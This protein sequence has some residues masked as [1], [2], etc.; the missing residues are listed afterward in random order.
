MKP[1]I[2]GVVYRINSKYISIAVR[3]MV[4]EDDFKQPLCAVMMPNDVTF[5]RCKVAML[6][7]RDGDLGESA[8]LR[9]VLMEVDKPYFKKIEGEL[10]PF[11]SKLNEV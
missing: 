2:E 10:H 11:N 5:K 9:N 3:E 7:M 1:F 4:S 6:N 8:R